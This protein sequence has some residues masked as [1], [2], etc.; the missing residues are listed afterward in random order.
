[1]AIHYAEVMGMRVVAVD[2]D[3]RNGKLRLS[4]RAEHFIDD[5]LA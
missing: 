5:E 2:G 3:A 4:F 1:M